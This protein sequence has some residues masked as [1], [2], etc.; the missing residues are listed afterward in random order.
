LR[1]RKPKD[2]NKLASLAKHYLDA[3]ANSN[4]EWPKKPMFKGQDIGERKF[5]RS[6]RDN[7]NTKSETEKTAVIVVR[8]VIWLEIVR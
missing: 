3:H 2:L 1:E 7:R 4:K 8:L 6:G 5:E